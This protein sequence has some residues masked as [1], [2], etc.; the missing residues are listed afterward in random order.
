MATGI[1]KALPKIMKKT[2]YYAVTVMDG[3]TVK[4]GKSTS[5][6][7]CEAITAKLS[8]KWEIVKVTA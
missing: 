5:R 8:G 6:K 2:M 3:R 4:T 1:K 7:V